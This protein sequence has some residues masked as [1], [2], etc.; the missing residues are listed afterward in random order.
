MQLLELSARVSR[1]LCMNSRHP[2]D[3]AGHLRHFHFCFLFFSIII[4]IYPTKPINSNPPALGL[5]SRLV[6]S[7]SLLP[8]VHFKYFFTLRS[9]TDFQVIERSSD[10]PLALVYLAY[11]LEDFF[12]C[13]ESCSSTSHPS[14]WLVCVSS[15]Y[16]SSTGAFI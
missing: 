16:L 11:I 8:V 12:R 5:C 2:K 6:N 3:L 9:E 1:A 14:R 7:K 13:G 15:S 4:R 10:F